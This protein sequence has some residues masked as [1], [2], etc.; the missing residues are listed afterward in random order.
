MERLSKAKYDK[1]VKEIQ[2]YGKSGR[3]QSIQR[4]FTDYAQFDKGNDTTRGKESSSNSLQVEHGGE[5]P[6]ILRLDM[7]ESQGQ[8]AQRNGNG[9]SESGSSSKQGVNNT[10][11][12]VL[13]I[14]F[15]LMVRTYSRVNKP[16]L[17]RK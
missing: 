11:S 12:I 14:R 4:T 3:V 7:A 16:S 17:L 5:N 10:G 1:I 15:C 13:T 2:E 6:Q 9:N 8:H